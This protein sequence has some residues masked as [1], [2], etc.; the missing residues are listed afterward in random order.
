MIQPEGL[1]LTFLKNLLVNELIKSFAFFNSFTKKTAKL[2]SWNRSEASIPR[3]ISHN[4]ANCAAAASRHGLP[5]PRF[6]ALRASNLCTS[7]A[8]CASR[9]SAAGA[10]AQEPFAGESKKFFGKR[11]EAGVRL[12]ILKPEAWILAS[13]SKPG[14]KS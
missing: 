5:R 14:F 1:N 11:C 10:K 3:T 9:P 13:F 2:F 6:E 7:L 8:A 12:Q 4:V